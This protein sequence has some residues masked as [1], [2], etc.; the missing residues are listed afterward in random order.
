MKVQSAVLALAVL[1]A[2]PAG[3]QVVRYP[4]KDKLTDAV[5]QQVVIP[6]D[7]SALLL[8][9]CDGTALSGLAL[10]AMPGDRVTVAWRVDSAPA[11]SIE[12]PV[13]AGNVVAL[14]G[15]L[16][17]PVV[18]ALRSGSSLFVR[19]TGPLGQNDADFAVAHDSDAAFATA[20]MALGLKKMDA[21]MGYAY[22]RDTIS[23]SIARQDEGFA[24]LADKLGIKL[25]DGTR[26]REA[27][28]VLPQFLQG[29]YANRQRAIVEDMGGTIFGGYAW[30]LIKAIVRTDAAAY[31]QLNGP[32][33][34]QTDWLKATCG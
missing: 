22:L 26:T 1:C 16:D 17:N 10:P 12:R 33:A 27:W 34:Q 5:T 31:R 23:R 15:G 28:E 24:S 20:A 11:V 18:A 32:S 7:K 3:A 30:P 9:R 4:V 6:A 14:Y 19:V 25:R 8:I 2:A 21:L 13:Q 29:L